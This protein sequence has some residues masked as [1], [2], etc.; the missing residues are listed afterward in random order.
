MTARATGRFRKGERGYTLAALLVAVTVLNIGLAIALPV[1]SKKIQ[2]EKEEE[3][4]AR[5]L[6]YA[7]AI[8][9]FQTRFGRLPLKLEELIEVEPRSMRQLWD[10]P[11]TEDGKWGLIFQAGPG[12]GGIAPNDPNQ[13]GQNQNQRGRRNLAQGTSPGLERD[14]DDDR[15]TVGPISGVYSLSTEDSIL[16][17]NNANQHSEWKFDIQLL[18]AQQMVTAQEGAAPLGPAILPARWIGRPFRQGITVQMQTPLPVGQGTAPGGRVGSPG[19]GNQLGGPGAQQEQQPPASPFGTPGVRNN[20]GQ[21]PPNAN[22]RSPGM[23]ETGRRNRAR[24]NNGFRNNG[25]RDDGRQ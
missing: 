4:I 3:L 10:D 17:F 1:W 16:T 19:Q 22:L 12:A 9:V 21:R 7:Q 24:Q 14:D 5:G 6:Q 13:R 25:G 18:A 20:G 23:A 11:M 2:R 15:V 8:Q